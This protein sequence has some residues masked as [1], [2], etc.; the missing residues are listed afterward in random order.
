MDKGLEVLLTNLSHCTNILTL[1]GPHTVGWC[2]MDSRLGTESTH[3]LVSKHKPNPKRS[4]ITQV[5]KIW[6]LNLNQA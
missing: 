4:F 5:K 1:R 2:P 3:T 6:L